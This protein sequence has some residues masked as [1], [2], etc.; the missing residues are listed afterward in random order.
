[1]FDVLAQVLILTAANYLLVFYM[2]EPVMGPF[3]TFHKLR[4]W[5]GLTPEFETNIETG[6]QTLIGYEDGDSFFSKLLNCHKCFS[7]WA[8]ASL[9]ILSW[10]VGFVEPDPTNLVLWLSVSGATVF[11]LE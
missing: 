11:L 4:L 8:A 1:M 2:T 5:V 7:P 6:S 3:D 9:I 10:L